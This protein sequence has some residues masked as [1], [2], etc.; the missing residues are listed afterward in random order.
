MELAA[1]E[2]TL[3]ALLPI[4]RIVPTTRTRITASMTAYSAMSWP[5]SCRQNSRKSSRRRLLISCTSISWAIVLELND[6]HP[7]S[8]SHSNSR[9]RKSLRGLNITAEQAPI[10][11]TLFPGEHSRILPPARPIGLGWQV[12]LQRV[13][14]LQPAERPQRLQAYL[15]VAHNARLGD[16]MVRSQRG[17][18]SRRTFVGTAAAK[19][20]KVPLIWS[21]SF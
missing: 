14:L 2:N 11:L 9:S 12:L 10:I 15:S 17:I 3:F 21:G 8:S 18:V 20:G 1:F 13:R 16:W 5:S 7:I 19:Q 6:A 4:N